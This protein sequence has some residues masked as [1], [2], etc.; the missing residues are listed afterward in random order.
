[1][2]S[3]G[4]ISIQVTGSIEGA[5]FVSTQ[6]LGESTR[7]V[8]KSAALQGLLAANPAGP[9]FVSGV[10]VLVAEDGIGSV[11]PLETTASE[12]TAS[13]LRGDIRIH[14]T[15]DLMVH[16][17]VA[18]DG[19]VE[20]RVDGELSVETIQVGGAA[21]N[22]VLSTANGGDVLVGQIT[23]MDGDISITT[24]GAIGTLDG[25]EGNHL[26]SYR[27]SLTSANG[28]GANG[29]ISMEVSEL[30]ATTDRGDMRLANTGDLLVR[31]A[32]AQDGSI[33]LSVEGVLTIEIL[34]A[35][36]NGDVAL[37]TIG[38]GD[39][40]VGLATATG[41][42]LSI[43]SSGAIEELE[44]DPAPEV[45]GAEVVLTAGTNIGSAGSLEAAAVDLEAT[46]SQGNVHVA[47][48]VSVGT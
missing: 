30:T 28:V 23:A 17:A 46:A 6:R 44:D 2:G 14:N 34:R 47:N 7:I 5:S 26:A 8:R 22:V 24:D 29:I 4:T 41:N 13:T 20:I 37:S 9:D 40:T 3:E 42:R 27:L 32:I 48:Q 43:E 33:E 36:G 1:M 10:L 31:Y 25:L 16:Q 35:H 11:S 39:V 12:F 21:H 15:G 19:I 38:G 45:V 18:S